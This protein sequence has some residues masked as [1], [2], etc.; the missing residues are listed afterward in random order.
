M[1]ES[2]D[3]GF[4]FALGNSS[5]VKVVALSETIVPRLANEFRISSMVEVEVDE[6]VIWTSNHLEYAS[7]SRRNIFPS[8]GPAVDVYS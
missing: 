5:L 1:A 8:N 3:A 4:C 6:F 2:F 7:I